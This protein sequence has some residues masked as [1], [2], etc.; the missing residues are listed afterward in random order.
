MSNGDTVLKVK[1][2]GACQVIHRTGKDSISS[3]LFNE[4]CVSG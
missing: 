2:A 1:K 4:Y 3:I